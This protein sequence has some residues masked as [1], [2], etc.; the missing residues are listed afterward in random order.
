MIDDLVEGHPLKE[1][2]LKELLGHTPRQV[3]VGIIF[4]WL[5]GG[6]VWWL[7]KSGG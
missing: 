3:F 2:E 1:K 5:I 4:G 6:L 7:L